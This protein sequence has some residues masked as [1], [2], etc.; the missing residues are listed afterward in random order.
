IDVE[1]GG[2]EKIRIGGIRSKNR[3]NEYEDRE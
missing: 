2:K 1:R 3:E